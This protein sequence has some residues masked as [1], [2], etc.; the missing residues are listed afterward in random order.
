L[1]I[2][3]LI[4]GLDRKVTGPDMINMVKGLPLAASTAEEKAAMAAPVAVNV[5]KITVAVAPVATPS[6]AVIEPAPAAEPIVIPL[7][8]AVVSASNRATRTSGT[9]SLIVNP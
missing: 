6:A 5:N 7:G 4:Q 1:Q 3:L 8:A 9:T 2:D